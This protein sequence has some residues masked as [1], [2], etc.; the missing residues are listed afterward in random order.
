MSDAPTTEAVASTIELPAALDTSAAPGLADKLRLARGVPL[1]LSAKNVTR[2]G[3]LC[4]QVLLSAAA[5]WR[6]DGSRLSIA[7]P[8]PEFIEALRLMGLQPAAI[9]A[10]DQTA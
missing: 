3:G 2:L 10:G 4:A 8:S 1:T 9:T 5:S 6:A 7:D